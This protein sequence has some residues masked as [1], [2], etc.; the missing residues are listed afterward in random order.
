ML[1]ALPC[2]QAQNPPPILSPSSPPPPPGY[3]PPGQQPGADHKLKA[4][5]EL[6]VLHVTVS[7][8]RGQFVT[9]L[10]QG[11]FKVFEQNIEQTVS[12]F[13]RRHPGDHGAGD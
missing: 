2:A 9:D 5:V 10:K 8:E 11:N 3:T 6:V 1:C 7:D 12:F 4:A 13:T